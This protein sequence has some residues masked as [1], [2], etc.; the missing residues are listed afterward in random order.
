MTSWSERMLQ[1]RSPSRLSANSADSANSSLIRPIGANGTIGTSLPALESP[2]E[3]ELPKP[4]DRRQRL[5][6]T[7]SLDPG[8]DV[9]P[10]A[11]QHIGSGLADNGNAGWHRNADE[12]RQHVQRRLDRLPSPTCEHGRRLLR[13]T[14]SFLN[15]EHWPA[16]IALDW[17]LL[18]LFGI[19]GGA[20]AERIDS[21]GLITGLALSDLAGGRIDAIESTRATIRYR[22]GHVL[23][24]C[25]GSSGIASAELWWECD[26][27][28]GR[29]D[30]DIDGGRT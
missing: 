1:V 17:D 20:P 2:P 27:I 12:L 5:P 15:S 8:T 6:T 21:Q 18:E 22:S 25:R 29:D 23:V 3:T 14:S 28:I 10:R 16:A 7:H 19:N 9:A 4:S 24:R 13:C 11:E 30:L 26:A